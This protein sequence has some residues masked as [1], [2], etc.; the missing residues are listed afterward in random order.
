[1]NTATKTPWH[2]WVVGIIALIWNGFGASD[3][4]MTQTE[5]RDWFTGMG[6]DNAQTDAML[7][8]METQPMWT[9]AA[10]ALGVWGGV[11]AA[12]LLLLRK[13]WAVLAF[14]VSLLG[15]F[16]GLINNQTTEYPADLQ[17]MGESPMM[18]FIVA[19]AAFFLWYAWKQRSS[20]VL[21]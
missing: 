6:F 4:T 19:I 7:A 18:F 3:Y 14:A 11:V 20:G 21:S 15:A 8:F 12:V 2:L 13:R 5:N 1:M 9:H 10:W 16:L 17:E